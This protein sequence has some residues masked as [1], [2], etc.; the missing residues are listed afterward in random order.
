MEKHQNH[1]ASNSDPGSAVHPVQRRPQLR[2]V[3]SERESESFSASALNK[4]DIWCSTIQ[5]NNLP[6]KQFMI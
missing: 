6:L 5:E 1:Q 4:D 2:K 3:K